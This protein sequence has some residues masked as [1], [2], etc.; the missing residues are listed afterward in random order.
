MARDESGSEDF[1]W[2]YPKSYGAY[3][4]RD[5]VKKTISYYTEFPFKGQKA[6]VSEFNNTVGNNFFNNFGG[7]TYNVI[8]AETSVVFEPIWLAISQGLVRGIPT[9][10]GKA[11]EKWGKKKPG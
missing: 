11:H 5:G 3:G 2:S 6:K 9:L 7:E 8:G 4:V 10:Y 1:A